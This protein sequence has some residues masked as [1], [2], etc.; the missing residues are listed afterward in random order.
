MVEAVSELRSGRRTSW[1]LD[2]VLFW[3]GSICL[4]CGVAAI[5]AGW[6]GIAHTGYLW[7]Q[8]SYMISGGMLGL[9]LV[10]TG[11][12]LLFGSWITRHIRATEAGN[13]AIVA[14]LTA[15]TAQMAAAPNA[16]PPLSRNG[17]LPFLVTE[18][19]GLYHRSGCPAVAGKTNLRPVGP[20]P[21]GYRP[22]RVCQPEQSAT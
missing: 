16:A 13:H 15:L 12:F 9:G 8:N 3:L 7:Q 2:S 10:I 1:T 17:S 20:D 19:G 21:D 4:P 14:A 5:L 6:Y 18:K 11:G 22:C